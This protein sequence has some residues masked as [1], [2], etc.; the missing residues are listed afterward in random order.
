M[1]YLLSYGS[2]RCRIPGVNGKDSG[3]S[4]SGIESEKLRW[5]RAQYAPLDRQQKLLMLGCFFN[6]YRGA[7]FGVCTEQ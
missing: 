5:N 4:R 7:E 2:K 1:D 3:C 6:A